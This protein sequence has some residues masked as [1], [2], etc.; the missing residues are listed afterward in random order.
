MIQLLRESTFI[1]SYLAKSFL[2]KLYYRPWIKWSTA[3]GNLIDFSYLLT[4]NKEIRKPKIVRNLDQVREMRFR[5]R[6]QNAPHF[7]FWEA[8]PHSKHFC[9]LWDKLLPKLRGSAGFACI[10]TLLMGGYQEVGGLLLL[11]KEKKVIN[12]IQWR[13]KRQSKKSKILPCAVNW[14]KGTRDK[15]CNIENRSCSRQ[16]NKQHKPLRLLRNKHL[17]KKPIAKQA[18]NGPSA[19]QEQ[20]KI[21]KPNQLTPS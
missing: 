21:V 6:W 13:S 18:G 3:N 7:S 19:S 8:F 12:D 11:F 14:I 17:I 9:Q 4:C 20:T 5:G 2:R 1:S 16:T 15:K 10:K